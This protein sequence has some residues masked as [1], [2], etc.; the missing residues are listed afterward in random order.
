MSR[1]HRTRKGQTAVEMLFILGVVLAGIV[2]V[3]PVYTQQSSDSV[4]LSAVRDAASQATAYI[5][6]G[7]LSNDSAYAP[8]NEVINNYTGYSNAGFR[9]LGVGVLSENSTAIVLSV[10]FEHSL[11]SNSTQDGKMAL[12]VGNF[13]KG[14]LGGISGFNLRNGHLYADNRLLK[15]NVTVGETWEVVS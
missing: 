13:I 5:N 9:F 10:K 1:F 7:V 15:F 14:Y 8:L 12:A 4:V 3:V 6:M 2:V 11:P